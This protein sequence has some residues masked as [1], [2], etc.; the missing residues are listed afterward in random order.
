[1]RASQRPSNGRGH[2]DVPKSV[3]PAPCLLLAEPV[4]SSPGGAKGHLSLLFRKG[5]RPEPA[6]EKS[7]SGNRT[8]KNYFPNLL[9][10]V[11]RPTS[12]GPKSRKA[13]G[14]GTDE[15]LP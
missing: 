9:L 15:G 12:P 14:S 11:P 7:G 3:R 2:R 6:Y 1:M 8:R 10:I 4:L 13:A 5:R